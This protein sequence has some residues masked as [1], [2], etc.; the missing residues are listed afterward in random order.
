M[1]VTCRSRSV[2]IECHISHTHK[3]HHQGNL[4]GRVGIQCQHA[5]SQ[6]LCQP[7]WFGEVACLLR[8]KVKSRSTALQ[9]TAHEWHL[10]LMQLWGSKCTSVLWAML[11]MF[12][13]WLSPL[14]RLA[15]LATTCHWMSTL[16]RAA[17]ASHLTCR[18]TGKQAVLAV[19]TS[20]HGLH[21][22]D[23]QPCSATAYKGSYMLMSRGC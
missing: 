2:G 7:G 3:C 19:N 1:H 20:L 9:V 14:C 16:A 18:Q 11:T 10:C 8:E 22:L 13:C 15:M 23:P 12:V 5:T 4:G 21:G 6:I 17:G